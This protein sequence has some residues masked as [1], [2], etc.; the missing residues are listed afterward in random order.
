MAKDP[1]YTEDVKDVVAVEAGILSTKGLRGLVLV[2]SGF[3]VALAFWVGVYVTRI[4]SLEAAA[5]KVPSI[6]V[7]AMK[8]DTLTQEVTRLQEQIN[9]LF[10]KGERAR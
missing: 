2:N 1:E 3:L 10:E 4:N 9:R 6:E 8:I 5:T 7:M